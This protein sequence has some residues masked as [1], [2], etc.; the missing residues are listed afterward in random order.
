[1]SKP[2]L[3]RAVRKP[4]ELAGLEVDP[5]LVDALVDD[6]A[7]ET[8]GLPLLST[9]LVELW[10]ARDGRQLT[11]E[12]YRR[13][14][15]V[16]GIVE[17]H[18][19]AAYRSLSADEQVAARRIFLWLVSGGGDE[20][21]VRRRARREELG[22][23]EETARV[24]ARLVERRLVVAG[25]DGIELVH[26][27]LLEQWPRLREW[28]EE[29]AQARRMRAQVA[30][31]AAAWEAAGRSRD[32]LLRGA[33]L[34]AVVEWADASD[35]ALSSSDTA[36]V[37]ASRMEHARQTRRLRLGLAVALLLLLV[38][39]ARRTRRACV[40]RVGEPAG[41][42][43]D[44]A[45]TGRTG[46]VGAATRPCAPARPRG[47][48]ARRHGSDA[49]RPARDPAAEP[50]CAQGHA[51]GRQSRPRRRALARTGACSQSAA[52]TAVSRSSTRA[53]APRPLAPGTALRTSATPAR[54]SCLSGI[55]HS[56][57]TAATLAVGDSDGPWPRSRS[58][59]WPSRHARVVRMKRGAATADVAYAPDG[60]T[61]VTGEVTTGRGPNPPEKLV[62]R[63][64]ADGAELRRS[65]PIEAGP[66]CRLRARRS[67]P[68]RHKRRQP[69]TAA[70]CANVPP[71]ALVRRGWIAGNRGRRRHGRLRP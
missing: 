54:S 11:S 65:A 23:G 64:A 6:V 30:S 66:A 53:R 28:L 45:T 31:A 33:R 59:I 49:E 51:S 55:S 40:T 62:R 60:R 2:E 14:G 36:F 68:S 4:A 3:R 42:R 13:L 29:D 17:R 67:E 18:A 26:E 70:R 56:V 47:D 24:L 43:C 7:S 57:P 44:R 46:A 48:R 32:E 38:A 35:E 41:D 16:H 19:E 52:T 58:W 39:V 61:I 15:G 71:G 37:E 25:E 22:S 21:A 50:D 5:E 69:R 12:T 63:R 20:P 1:M 27:A 34:A 8:G 10:R 9:A